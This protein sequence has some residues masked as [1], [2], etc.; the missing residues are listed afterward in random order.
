MIC[1]QKRQASHF[2]EQA[3]EGVPEIVDT[4]MA[5]IAKRSVKKKEDYE[6]NELKKQ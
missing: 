4:N 6:K 2:N 3:G 1:K 5:Q